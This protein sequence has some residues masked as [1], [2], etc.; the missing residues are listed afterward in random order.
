MG[1][2]NKGKGAGEGEKVRTVFWA[3]L[4]LE[5]FRFFR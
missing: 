2:K 4:E 5:G 3:G 1:N